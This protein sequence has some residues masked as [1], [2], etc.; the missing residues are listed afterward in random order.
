MS[1]YSK[2]ALSIK[3]DSTWTSKIIVDIP[4][5]H[6]LLNV[7]NSGSSKPSFELLK[8]DKNTTDIVP[9]LNL[10]SIVM[11]SELETILNYPKDASFHVQGY[12]GVDD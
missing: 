9:L 7:F 3:A 6:S 1:Q 5:P 10:L 11:K 2:L 8:V 4:V 12:Q